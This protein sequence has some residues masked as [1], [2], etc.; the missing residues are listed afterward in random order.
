[1]FGWPPLIEILAR[2]RADGAFGAPGKRADARATLW[3]L[4]LLRRCG[5]TVD[6]EP[7]ARA[8]EALERDHV[9][10]GVLT[11]LSGGSGVLPRYLGVGVA[12]L[13]GLGA[14]ESPLV[15]ASVD[16]GRCARPRSG[17]ASTRHWSTCG[18]TGS[19]ARRPRAGRCFA[20]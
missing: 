17:C 14:T 1:M 12:A 8:V 3:A 16:P 11:Y 20:T 15:W 19:I 2:Q 18:G 4:C 13:L 5:C 10:D 9:H 7:V 6:D